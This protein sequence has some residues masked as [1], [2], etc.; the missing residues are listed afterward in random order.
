MRVRLRLGTLLMALGLLPALLSGCASLARHHEAMLVLGDLSAGSEESRLKRRTEAPRREGVEYVRRGRAYRADVYHPLE[1][2]RGS[3]ILVHGFTEQ[4]R[5]DPRLVALARTLGRVGFRVMVPELDGL[6]DYSISTREVQAIVDAV[7]Y[8]TR[9][10]SQAPSHTALAAVSFAVGPTLIAAMDQE[11]ASAVSFVVAVGGYYDMT[12]L[13]RYVTTGEDRGGSAREAPPPQR[14]ARWAVLMSQLHWL[15]D[16]QDRA[17]LESIAR[18]RLTDP[19]SSVRDEARRLGPSGSALYELVTNED[20]GRIEAL[21]DKLPPA[22]VKELEALD[23]SR[24]PLD[25]LHARL[26]LIHGPQDRVIPIS[27]SR[28]LRDALPQ[29][30]ARLFETQALQH[31]AV[32]PDWRDGWGL[33]RALVHVLALGEDKGEDE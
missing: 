16:A 14:E 25:R 9:T 18:R 15:E 10:G 33:W 22:L 3:L 27:H 12:D 19:E 26:V 5:R 11:V 4:G 13:L 21:I 29:G 20:P 6:R 1:P 28:R 8:A 31:V 23:P 32:S 17:L 2:R 30:Q 7:H 24:Q